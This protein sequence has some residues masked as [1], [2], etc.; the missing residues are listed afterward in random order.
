MN[1][2]R[3]VLVALVVVVVAGGSG[4]CLT[5]NPARGAR[6]TGEY[7][8]VADNGALRQ[9]GQ[10]LDEQDFY[11]IAGD[12][13]AAAAVRTKR[14]NLVAEQV[15]WQGV[16]LASIGGLVLGA[17]VM[18]GGIVWVSASGPIG[19]IA[20]LPGVGLF[21]TNL[22]LVPLAYVW[23]ADAADAM[24]QPVFGRDRA[25]AA[26]ERYNRRLDGATDTRR[27]ARRRQRPP[28]RR[29][30]RPATRRP[31]PRSRGAPV[32]DSASRA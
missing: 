15:A 4:A 18:A 32:P 17:G 23:A 1:A 30:T 14:M 12:K 24:Y 16:G 26:A 20:L 19:L 7:L 5:T 10:L 13:S 11:R 3:R 21:M 22:V 25:R 27:P 31:A 29:T 28:R 9:G 8:S 2:L 6:A